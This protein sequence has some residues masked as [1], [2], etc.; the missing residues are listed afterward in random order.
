MHP[1]LSWTAWWFAT[2]SCVGGGSEMDKERGKKVWMCFVLELYRQ[3]KV[4]GDG[5][6]GEL[7]VRCK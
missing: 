6:K 4:G 1:V 3:E 7:Q 2:I 5:T